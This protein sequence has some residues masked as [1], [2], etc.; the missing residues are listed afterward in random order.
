MRKLGVP[1]PEPGALQ[2][3]KSR[4][5]TKVTRE[6]GAG[7]VSGPDGLAPTPARPAPQL[8]SPV[9]QP[10]LG[11]A[12][13]PRR[14]P[15]AGG[16]RAAPPA[17]PARAGT[18]PPACPP[19]GPRGPRPAGP[20]PPLA[21]AALTTVADD[22]QLEEVVVV[23]GHGGRGRRARAGGVGAGLAIRSSLRAAPAAADPLPE[24]TAGTDRNT[25]LGSPSSSSSAAAAAA[26]A[27]L[28]PAPP[29]HCA[30]A[31]PGTA[32][33]QPQPHPAAPSP[34]SCIAHAPR[35]SPAGAACRLRVSSAN[36]AAAAR[37]APRARRAE[38]LSSSK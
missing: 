16:C 24:Q 22:E 23:P 38:L 6:A 14:A 11:A 34:R 20:T 8:R 2:L 17:R 13:A 18:S 29:R 33:A 7:A 3:Q 21:T 9:P 12:P 5:L 35:H 15:G 10:H 31:A 30:G 1:G 32:S 19:R 26:A 25:S 37:A 4:D 27:S 28:L 36:V